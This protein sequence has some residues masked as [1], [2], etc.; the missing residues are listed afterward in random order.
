MLDEDL[1][2]GA[3]NLAGEGTTDN[4]AETYQGLA[5]WGDGGTV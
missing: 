1:E 2:V 3:L 5:D 4:S